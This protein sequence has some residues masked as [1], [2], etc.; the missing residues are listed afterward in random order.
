LASDGSEVFGGD[1]KTHI[2]RDD[3]GD[4]TNLN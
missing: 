1:A 3:A 4:V 2:A